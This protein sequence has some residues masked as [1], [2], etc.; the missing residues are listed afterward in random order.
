MKLKFKLGMNISEASI[1]DIKEVLDKKGYKSSLSHEF[2][3]GSGVRLLRVVYV[4][5]P[6]DIN[7]G[8]LFR[9]GITLGTALEYNEEAVFFELVPWPE[10]QEYMEHSWFRDEA[11]LHPNES[12]AYFIPI[13]YMECLTNEPEDDREDNKCDGL[14]QT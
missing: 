4:E 8:D 10:V 2:A 13:R 6:D 7:N 12:S 14:E 11:V 3:K 5:L 9:L 1:S